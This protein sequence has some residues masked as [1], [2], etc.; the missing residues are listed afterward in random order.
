MSLIYAFSTN[1]TTRVTQ[2]AQWSA[3]ATKIWKRLWEECVKK[4]YNQIWNCRQICMTFQKSI[5]RLWLVNIFFYMTTKILNARNLELLTRS[6]MWFLEGT[7]KLITFTYK[8]HFSH[9]YMLH[10]WFVV[11]FFRYRPQYPHKSC[12]FGLGR[13]RYWNLPSV[14]KNRKIKI[15]DFFKLF[16]LFSSINLCS[17]YFYTTRSV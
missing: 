9:C 2:Y 3:I 15:P 4:I 11:Y 12:N 17:I 7:L 13:K 14:C 10:D 5:R 8:L 6:L 1:F 16:F